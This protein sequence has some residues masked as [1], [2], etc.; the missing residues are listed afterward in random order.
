[1]SDAVDRR[2]A[3]ERIAN[4]NG[5]RLFRLR[6]CFKRHVPSAPVE[7]T[8]GRLCVGAATAAAPD[9]PALSTGNGRSS[10][11][12]AHVLVFILH[13]LVCIIQ[14]QSASAPQRQ[15]RV[16][17]IVLGSTVGAR[18]VALTVARACIAR[19]RRAARTRHALWIRGL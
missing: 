7:A 9:A 6:F 16:V 19:G 12:S 2:A 4:S 11:V 3:T 5:R 18:V 8:V 14:Q 10:L 15:R 17:G 1:V 13:N